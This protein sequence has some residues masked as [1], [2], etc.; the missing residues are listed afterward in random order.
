MLQTVDWL[1]LVPLLVLLV[2]QPELAIA[3]PSAVPSID[4]TYELTKRVMA[5]GTVLKPPSV[6]ALYTLRRG[7]F[8]LN[9][10]F[11]SPTARSPLNR[12][13]VATPSAR[14]NTASGWTTR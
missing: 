3:E 6:S 7:R 13:M 4:G 12:Q 2:G 1:R 9:L 14:Q 10:F 5:D 11:K 8:H